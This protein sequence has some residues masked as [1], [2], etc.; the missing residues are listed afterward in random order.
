VFLFSGSNTDQA[1][2]RPCD[3]PWDRDVPGLDTVI[4][5]ESTKA[6]DMLDVI[7]GKFLYPDLTFFEGLL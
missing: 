6:Y 4:P 7:L 5:L 2:I 1:P 3:D